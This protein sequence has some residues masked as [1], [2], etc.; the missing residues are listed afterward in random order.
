M[1]VCV[2]MRTEAKP[3][4]LGRSGS[5]YPNAR[6]SRHPRWNPRLHVL[7]TSPPG[8]IFLGFSCCLHASG[9]RKYLS[10]FRLWSRQLR[11]SHSLAT[12][13]HLHGAVF[14]FA[15]QRLA[16]RRTIAP[17]PGLQLKVTSFVADH[18]IVANR[19]F[20]LQ[21]KDLTK[22]LCRQLPP[23]IV[24]RL[25][26]RPRKTPIVPRQILLFQILVGR[27]VAVDPFSAHFL[28]Q[29]ILMSAVIPLDTPFC[30]GRT[31]RNDE[32]VQL[33]T[34]APELRDRNFSPQLLGRCRRTYVHVFPIGVECARHSVFLNP[35]P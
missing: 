5:A 19:T 8:V 12:V 31:G 24:L 2:G 22:F 30:L 23:V 20:R 14:P 9:R 13:V 7:I 32:N 4:S 1:F 25:G 10:C 18:P 26:R 17:V 27:G 3:C 28:D 6:R 21:A 35:P 29:A 11:K 15:D 16:F 34:H 33:L